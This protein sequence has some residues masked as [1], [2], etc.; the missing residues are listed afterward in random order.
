MTEAEWLAC[1]DPEAMV[2]FLWGK[3]Y[4]RK[5]RLFACACCRSVWS[6]LKD[7]RGR[8]ALVQAE[9][10]A[11]GQLT[12]ERLELAYS[13]AW[14]A[15]MEKTRAPYYHH[16]SYASVWVAY[17]DADVAAI[18]GPREAMNAL[19]YDNPDLVD[20][21]CLFQPLVLRDVIGNP[22][23]PVSFEPAWRTSNVVS[24]AQTIFEERELPSGLLDRARL[25]VL[26]DALMDAGCDNED[27]LGHCRSEG[28]HVRGCWVIDLLLG[29]E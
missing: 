22:F 8:E 25:A 19:L 4:D 23:R 24:L 13:S 6:L 18:E 11:E 10:L 21:N 16:A 28:P 27:I 12:A 9:A 15:Y 5:L 29:K 17:F 7:E 3:A 14:E 1:E 26:A 2:R 20:K